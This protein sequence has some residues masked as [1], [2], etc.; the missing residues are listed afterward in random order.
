MAKRIL[1]SK[2]LKRAGMGLW[3]AAVAGALS[4]AVS[5]P[6]FGYAEQ[7]MF[8][9]STVT[10]VSYL[11]PAPGLTDEVLE[12]QLT[13][14][15]L[16]APRPFRCLEIPL[17]RELQQYTYQKCREHGLEYELV[18]AI[19]WRESGF[20]TQAVGVNANG[21]RDSGLMQINDVNRPWLEA[22]HGIQ[23]LL[24]PYQNI[25][26]GTAI[27]GGYFAKYGENQALMA[28]QY[29]EQGMLQKVA[30]GMETNFLT[31]KVK[32]K[33]DEFAALPATAAN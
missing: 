12:A 32:A 2:T 6:G 1:R 26:A 3:G 27:L 17:S 25:D 24:D 28:Y 18:L 13:A 19:M 5:S 20:Q 30:G 10:T 31:E 15:G 21:T 11:A 23:D 22:E 7:V 16:P 33:R 8:R 14:L 4:V 9:A 29:G